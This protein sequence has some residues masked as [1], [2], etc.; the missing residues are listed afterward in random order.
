M[1]SH[2]C[3]ILKKKD[4]ASSKDFLTAGPAFFFGLCAIMLTKIQVMP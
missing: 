4:S 2:F 3:A 1:K